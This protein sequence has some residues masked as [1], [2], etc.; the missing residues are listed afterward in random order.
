MSKVTRSV[1]RPSSF[2][3]AFLPEAAKRRSSAARRSRPVA[4]IGFETLPPR[5]M[6]AGDIA[7]GPSQVAEGSA[8]A[9]QLN[10]TA[11][12]T[13]TIKWGDGQQ[14]TVN[15]LSPAMPVSSASHV[16]ADGSA[17]YTISATFKS[18]AASQTK[19]IPVKVLNVAPQVA[20]SGN[21]FSLSGDKYKLERSQ[22]I[23]PGKDTISKWIVNW[24]EGQPET[25]PGSATTFQHSYGILAGG[26]KTVK[27]TAVDEDGSYQVYNARVFLV[28]TLV[29][30]PLPSADPILAGALR[31]KYGAGWEEGYYREIMKMQIA[32]WRTW[33]YNLAAN[34]MEHFLK[35]SGLNYT[36]NAADKV[37]AQ[38]HGYNLIKNEIGKDIAKALRDDPYA[39]RVP[40]EILDRNVG[41]GLEGATSG[42][43]DN[44]HMFNAYGGAELTVRGIATRRSPTDENWVVAKAFVLIADT[45]DWGP[46]DYGVRLIHHVYNA[47]HQLQTRF[48]YG[49]FRTSV[50]FEDTYTPRVLPPTGNENDF[51]LPGL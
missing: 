4:G 31:G 1:T 38:V 6:L 10:T 5:Q 48:G 39:T 29:G 44:P 45:Y 32:A 15:Q 51:P 49:K 30:V 28:P 17:S 21:L 50:Q 23:D 8:Y 35:N 20:I 25:Y 18:A 47:G 43:L 13:W 46:T 11:I 14:S 40:I 33:G 27:V 16:Y 22:V 34:H 26:S 19:S 7:A 2:L 42:E 24:G 9:L 12:G 3:A 41:W 36:G 37:E